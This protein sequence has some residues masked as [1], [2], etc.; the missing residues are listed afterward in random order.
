[1]SLLIN[2]KCWTLKSLI[3]MTRVQ[4]SQKHFKWINDKRRWGS[5]SRSTAFVQI[6]IHFT[7]CSVICYWKCEFP[8]N[9]H[10]CLLVGQTQFRKKGRE[11]TLFE[12]VVMSGLSGFVCVMVYGGW[13]H[14]DTRAFPQRKLCKGVLTM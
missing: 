10:V 3:I 8:M 14:E 6:R 12:T 1:M 13:G 5:G 2:N 9:P 4:L 7:P 11:D